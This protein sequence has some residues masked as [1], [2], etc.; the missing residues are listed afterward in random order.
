MV[1]FDFETRKWSDLL[2][3]TALA[4]GVAWQNWSHDGQYVYFVHNT[5]KVEVLRIRIS[6]KKLE[7]VVD[8]NTFNTVGR[9]GHWLALNPND[10]PLV[11]RDT[12][13]QDVYSLDWEE[14]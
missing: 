1:L 6:D 10:S 3:G 2:A 12:G 7:K 8:L 5:G 9:W 11:L 14:P 4:G 13:T